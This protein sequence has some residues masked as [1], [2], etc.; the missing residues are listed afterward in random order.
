VIS[1]P[2]TTL[3]DFSDAAGLR[4]LLDPVVKSLLLILL[5]GLGSVFLRHKAAS[6]RST[7]LTILLVGLVLVPISGMFAPWFAAPMVTMAE[8]PAQVTGLALEAGA[9]VAGDQGLANDPVRPTT[10]VA[11]SFRWMDIPWRGVLLVLWGSLAGF[12][13]LR[14]GA[15]LLWIWRLSS[16]AQPLTE[17]HIQETVVQV[18]RDGGYRDVRVCISRD[19]SIPFV[20]GWPQARLILPEAARDWPSEKLMAILH[21]ELAHIS[22]HDILRLMVAELACALNWHNPLVWRMAGAAALSHEMACDD[23]AVQNG[24]DRRFYARTLLNMAAGLSADDRVPVP[25]LARPSGVELRLR[26][27]MHS[28]RTQT[29]Q[30]MNG[31]LIVLALL[32]L[33]PVLSGSSVRTVAVNPADPQPEQTNELASAVFDAPATL[34]TNEPVA[35]DIHELVRQGAIQPLLQLLVE[36]PDLLEARD[37]KGMTPLAVAAWSGNLPLLDELLTLGANPDAKNNNGLAPVF[38]ALDRGKHRVAARLADAGADLTVT[39]YRNWTLLHTAARTNDAAFVERLLAA[40][41][42]PNAVS[43]EGRTAMHWAE[44]FDYT[45]VVSQ[46]RQAGAQNIPN[47][48]P[49]PEKP[50]DLKTYR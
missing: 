29:R 11:A 45:D 12:F 20:F 36:Q 6:L 43:T 14:M 50:A 39:G 40:G 31:L 27:V 28:G 24:G 1:L 9:T 10:D 19:S 5:A 8:A 2:M 44:R 42:D 13:L 15:R 46:L 17:G 48:K 35:M 21:H 23:H 22:R 38:S 25:G 7:W 33:F 49:W 4:L 16:A 47:P 18:C 30:W 34:P 3:P 41:L 32:F 37:Q 26:H